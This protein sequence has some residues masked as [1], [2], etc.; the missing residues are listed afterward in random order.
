M[1]SVKGKLRKNA[2]CFDQSAF[3]NFALYVI[4]PENIRTPGNQTVNQSDTLSLV[5]T[6]GGSPVPN[7]TWTKLPQNTLANFSLTI[8]G[9][10]DEGYYRC[11]ADNGVGNPATAQIFITVE[12]KPIG[13]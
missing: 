8:T 11:T 12:S 2:L 1:P 10:Q 9:K 13:I 7:V 3:S 6:A 4:T 5:C